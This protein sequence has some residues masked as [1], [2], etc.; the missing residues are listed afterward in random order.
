MKYALPKNATELNKI[1]QSGIKS[2]STMRTKVQQAAVAILYHAYKCGDWTSANALVEGLGHG[3]KRDSLVEFFTVNGGLTIA[4][5][6]KEF[7]G[8][9][10]ADFIKEK[11]EEAKEN[12]WWDYKKQNPFAG[13]EAQKEFDKLIKRMESMQKMANDDP[14]AAEKI[15]L[16]VNE[17]AVRKLMGL[18]NLEA[19]IEVEEPANDSVAALEAIVEA[20]KASA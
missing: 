9:K 17:A 1:I 5:G 4:E 8:W 2:A 19:L 14:D 15:H 6:A 20:D 18:V 3:V 7:T 10:G 11:F 12:M 13:F 16:E